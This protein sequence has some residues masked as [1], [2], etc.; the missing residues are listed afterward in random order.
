MARHTDP[1]CGMQ[2]DEEGAAGRSEHEGQIYYFCSGG[3]KAKFD[4]APE[5]YAA[6]GGDGREAGRQGGR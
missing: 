3:C 4:E 1:V 5:R 2:V 6:G